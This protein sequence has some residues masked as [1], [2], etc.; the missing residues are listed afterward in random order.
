M[1]GIAI[2]V[3][4]G[5]TAINVAHEL[6]HR[7]SRFEREAGGVLLASVGYSAFR[8]EHVLGHHLNVATPRDTATAQRGENVYGFFVK[9]FF[10]TLTNAWRIEKSRLR[11]RELPTYSIHNRYLQGCAVT[12][13]IA[14][15]LTWLFGVQAIG[16]MALVSFVAIFELEVIN[17]LEHYG[18]RLVRNTRGTRTRQ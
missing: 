4:G 3:I 8:I 15:I 18:N 10:G 1:I 9:S 14:T 13:A 5:I 12:V 6:I 2:G 17:Y 7:S 16:M 11:K